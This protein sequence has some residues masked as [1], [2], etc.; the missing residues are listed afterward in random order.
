MKIEYS[1]TAFKQLSKLDR[2]AQRQIKKYMD[3]IEKLENPRSKG[4]ALKG[5]LSEFWR[6]RTGDYRIICN[7]QDEKILITILTIAHRREVYRLKGIIK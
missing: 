2:S 5:N 1:A 6:Y 7:I 4:R 3:D